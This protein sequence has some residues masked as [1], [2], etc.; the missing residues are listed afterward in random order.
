MTYADWLRRAL[1]VAA[2][3]QNGL[4]TAT[5]LSPGRVAAYLVGKDQPTLRNAR[6]I[7]RALGVPISQMDSVVDLDWPEKRR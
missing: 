3:T 4:A 5:G 6:L 7:C 1:D 2:V